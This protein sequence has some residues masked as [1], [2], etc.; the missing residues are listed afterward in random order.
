MCVTNRH[1]KCPMKCVYTQRK[2]LWSSG[3][4]VVCS[5][6]FFNFNFIFRAHSLCM[7]YKLLVTIKWRNI[8]S[9][10]RWDREMCVPKMEYSSDK[11]KAASFANASYLYFLFIFFVGK[12]FS[13]CSFRSIVWNLNQLRAIAL[14]LLIWGCL[15][16]S[17]GY[18]NIPIHMALFSFFST[19][20]ALTS[21]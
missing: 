17:N 1:T 9:K 4:F 3:S 12:R 5:Y 6:F 11:S 10:M 18:S 14:N 13:F 7:N 21:K 20:D 16:A 8:V 15:R 19:N 2:N